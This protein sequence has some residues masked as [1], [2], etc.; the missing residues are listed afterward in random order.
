VW[1][2]LEQSLALGEGLVDEA[3]LAL[4]EVAQAAVDQLGG[5]R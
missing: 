3:D 1:R 4:L 5:L 2:V